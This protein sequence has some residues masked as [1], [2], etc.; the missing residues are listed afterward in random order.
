MSI[1]QRLDK[2][3]QRWEANGKPVLAD[4]APGCLCPYRGPAGDYFTDV[5]ALVKALREAHDALD[6]IRWR[7]NPADVADL[8]QARAYDALSR[9]QTILQGEK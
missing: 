9:I 7:K 5:P 2:I 4:P 1:E 6:Y 3:E 8:M